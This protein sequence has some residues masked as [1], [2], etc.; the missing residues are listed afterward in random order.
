M[1]FLFFLPSIGISVRSGPQAH[2]RCSHPRPTTIP[3]GRSGNQTMRR[4][5]REKETAPKPTPSSYCNPEKRCRPRTGP[6]AQPDDTLY[7][8]ITRIVHYAPCVRAVWWP[9]GMCDSPATMVT[10]VCRRTVDLPRRSRRTKH[11]IACQNITRR[12]LIKR[13][14]SPVRPDA[15]AR[16]TGWSVARRSG[17]FGDSALLPAFVLDAY[18]VRKRWELECYVCGPRRLLIRTISKT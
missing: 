16:C 9:T 12:S 3:A 15:V 10:R 8:M 1:L 5:P 17:V 2:D 14:P 11:N 6:C 7:A 4:F 13:S 18:A